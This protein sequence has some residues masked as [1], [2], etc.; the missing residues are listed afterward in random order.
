MDG[1]GAPVLRTKRRPRTRSRCAARA[2]RR[3]E[4][5]CIRRAA[6]DGARLTAAGIHLGWVDDQPKAGA[7]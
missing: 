1:R 7:R 2:C 5:N 4:R 6:V 3:W